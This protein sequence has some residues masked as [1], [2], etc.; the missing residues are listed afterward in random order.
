MSIRDWEP[1]WDAVADSLPRADFQWDEVARTGVR[2]LH[3]A[4]QP[5][6]IEQVYSE[7]WEAWPAVVARAQEHGIDL[8]DLHGFEDGRPRFGRSDEMVWVGFVSRTDDT[9]EAVVEG[10]YRALSVWWS[11]ASRYFVRVRPNCMRINEHGCYCLYVARRFPG[12]QDYPT[13]PA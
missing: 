2:G 8:G 1:V 5:E 6:R 13:S 10:L 4:M 9:A 3:G 7:I 12:H 11:R